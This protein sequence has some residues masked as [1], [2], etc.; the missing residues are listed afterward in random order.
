MAN[1]VVKEEKVILQDGKELVVRPLNIKNLRKFM[2]VVQKFQ[3]IEDESE[4]EGLELML[5][6]VQ[7]ALAKNAPE[8]ADDRDY[9][10]ENLDIHNIY[11]IMNVA[12]G[13]DMSADPNLPRTG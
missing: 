7:I 9:L 2:E 1:S 6:C 12:G 4:M 5:D 10:E 8:I 11:Q 13:V 3:E